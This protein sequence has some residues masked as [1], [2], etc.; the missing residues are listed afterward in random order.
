LAAGSAFSGTCAGGVWIDHGGT[1]TGQVISAGGIT[2]SGKDLSAAAAPTSGVD[3]IRIDWPGNAAL[4]AAGTITLGTGGGAPDGVG[5][6]LNANVTTSAGDILVNNPV[7]LTGDATLTNSAAGAGAGNVRFAGPVDGG[8]DLTLNATGLASFLA[9]VGGGAAIGDGAGPAITVHSTGDT[10]FYGTVRTA[11]GIAATD[12]AATVRFDQDVTIGAGD[13]ATTFDGSVHLDGLTLSAG[14]D[15]TFGNNAASDRVTLSGAAVNVNT[16]ANNGSLTFHATVN[17][18]QNLALST[19]GA[20]DVDFNGVIGASDPPSSLTVSASATTTFDA[21]ATVAGHITT[22]S[23]GLTQIHANLTSNTG[24]IDLQSTGGNISQADDTTVLATLGGVCMRAD[25]GNVTVL[26][27]TAGA[28]SFPNHLGTPNT[29]AIK[30]DVAGTFTQNGMLTAISA[31]DLN[32]SIDPVDVHI[33]ANETATGDIYHTA[34][35]NITVY[36]GVRLE[37]DSDNTGHGTLTMIADNDAVGGGNL[38][39]QDGTQLI[40]ADVRLSGDNVTVDVVAG[41]TGNTTITGANNVTLND[42]VSAGPTTGNVD[43]QATAGTLRQTAGNMLA[44]GFVELD[45][46]TLVDLDGTMGTGTAVGGDVRINTNLA[47]PVQIDGNVSADGAVTIGRAN[48][49]GGAV[50]IGGAGSAV[51]IAA[52]ADNAGLEDLTIRAAAAIRQQTAGSRLVSSTGG[53]FVRSE[54]GTVSLVGAESGGANQ[55]TPAIAWDNPGNL[56]AAIQVSAWGTV[57]VAGVRATAGGAAVEVVS[58]TAEIALGDV[59]ATTGTVFLQ[60][61]HGAIADANDGAM[62]VTAAGLAARALLGIGDDANLIETA[63]SGGSLTLAAVTDSGDIALANAGHL[64]VGTVGNLSGV[65]IADAVN[66]NSALD[67][68]TLVASSP[69]T[70]NTPVVNNDGGDILL[71]AEGSADTDDLTVNANVTATGGNGSIYLYAGDDIF[72]NDG[73]ISAVGAGSVHLSAGEDYNPGSNQGGNVDGDVVMASGRMLQADT[74]TI[75]IEATRHIWLSVATTTGNVVL[76]ADDDDFGLADGTGAIVDNLAGETPNLFANVAT[77]RAGSGIGSG[78]GANDIQ[79]QITS[80]AAVNTTSGDIVINEVAAGRNLDVLQVVQTGNSG[81]IDL[82]VQRGNLRLLGAAAGGA[83]VRVTNPNNAT[84]AI[85]LTANLVNPADETAPRGD[86]ILNQVVTSSGGPITI[87]GDHDVRSAVAGVITSGGGPIDITADANLSSLGSNNDGTIQ[88]IGN[89]VAGT[90]TVSFRLTDYDGWIGAT[91]G[92]A[93]GNIVSAGDVIKNGPGVLRLNGRAH[94]YAGTT[95][96]YEGKLLVNGTLTADTALITVHAGATLG[97]TGTIGTAAGGRDVLVSSGGFLS[98]GEVD[99]T[100]A[101]SQPGL[102]TV[103]GDVTL[104]A[105]A[106]YEV[107]LQGLVAATQYDQLRVNGTVDLTADYTAVGGPTLELL[108][109]FVIPLGAA[110]RIIDNDAS[111]QIDTRFQDR[112]EGHFIYWG[113]YQLNI[114]YYAWEQNNDV[115]LTSAGRFDLNG[116]NGY[117]T[118]HYVGISPQLLKGPGNA[119]GWQTLPPRYFERTWPVLPP[120]ATEEERLKYDGHSTDRDG[121]SLT[122]EVDV[123]AG[124]AYQVTILTGDV[125]WNHDQQQFTVSGS[126][127]AGAS[128]VIDTWG[129]GAIDNSATNVI[130]GGGVANTNGTGFYRWIPFTTDVIGPVSGDLGKLYIRMQ[131][132]GGSDPTAVIL[133]LDIRPVEAVGRR[134]IFRAVAGADPLPAD[135]MTVDHYLGTGAPPFGKLTVTASAGTPLQYARVTPDGDV[136]LF[137]TQLT[138]DENGAF[139]FSLLRPA[140][141]TTPAETEDWT[142]RG[143]ELSG[144]WHGTLI[145]TYTAPGADDTAP[146]RFDFGISGSPVQPDFLPV[147]PQTT[148]TALRGYGWTTRVAGANRQD[149]NMSALRTDLNYAKDATFRVDLPNGTYSVR[150]YHANPKYYGVTTYIV[151]NFRV[152]AEGNLQYTITNIPAGTTDIQTFTVTVSDGVLDI[153]FQDFGGQDGNFVVSG[154][155]ISAGRLPSDMPLLAVG[156]PLDCGAASITTADLAPVVAEAAARWLAT[157]LTPD[158]AATLENVRYRVADLGGAYLGLADVAT[159]SIH[160]D[161]DAARLGW[162]VVTG[163]LSVVSGQWSVVRGDSFRTTDNGRR[164]TDGIDLLTVV[165]HELGHLLGY[166]HSDHEGDLM[167][168]VLSPSPSR[169]ARSLDPLNL[170]PDL[171]LNLPPASSPPRSLLSS[172]AG[173]LSS[174]HSAA[175][176]PRGQTASRWDATDLFAELTLDSGVETDQ[177]RMSRRSGMERYERELDRWFAELG[178]DL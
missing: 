18:A 31:A 80:L 15:V 50:T 150:V 34:S 138:A 86:V 23:S 49:A 135:G 119:Y 165:M 16:T 140:T 92:S 17:G 64:I 144:Q 45:A 130:W 143:S 6:L 120:Y 91:P 19:H 153:R 149:P 82:S 38:L 13:T 46:A 30:V 89:L 101:Y 81:H 170:S 162:S 125:T 164:T 103:N 63:A 178:E 100:T 27:V 60:A 85:R 43:V 157:G 134:T 1:F 174:V 67:N 9:A 169:I 112:P 124:Q 90:G 25:S 74:G 10:W 159:N 29:A 142:I 75:Q 155:E 118:E 44:G 171:S 4:S 2:I 79:T 109:G 7:I 113:G 176:E 172:S 127:Y 84:G 136:T 58:D 94:A 98:P 133:G 148:Y 51:V 55:L 104:A 173:P 66:N 65:T 102:L 70:V 57:A 123:V 59:T 48:Y 69:L 87:R 40:G 21:V 36:A 5:T 42:N 128:Q 47:G 73:L 53:V 8:H 72:F 131:D 145:E 88:L 33:H 68:I 121:N 106:V 97:G 161:D 95:N 115:V 151:D 93:S 166:D 117:T 158:Q 28:N 22:T 76:S 39:G 175:T 37:A 61:A 11:S 114:S 52:D 110:F 152:Y 122:F 111:E 160:I 77:L 177:L 147:I 54:C 83:G 99:L 14:R 3:A 167:A 108:D 137:G 105:G 78:G 24:D 26:N 129:A 12:D 32:I 139:A 126:G 107:Q 56:A 146:L 116:Y 156:D 41:K 141:L 132:L 20:G 163:H 168:P 35:N 154:I 96:V 62:N 71:A